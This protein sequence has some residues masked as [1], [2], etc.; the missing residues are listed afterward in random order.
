M[1]LQCCLFASHGTHLSRVY[2]LK[3][4]FEFP[5]FC[6]ESLEK[7]TNCVTEKC[8]DF[9]EESGTPTDDDDGSFGDFSCESFVKLL[10]AQVCEDN[11]CPAC[12]AEQIEH[13]ECTGVHTLELISGL[14]SAFDEVA[15]G[16][17][18]PEVEEK[19]EVKITECSAGVLSTLSFAF[20]AAIG[21]AL[22]L[23]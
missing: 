21:T 20:A 19:C 11:K 8:P 18:T 1:L 15:E 2:F 16:A 9:I 13:A 5:D 23:N 10:N 17:S 6:V 7:L 14:A 3:E 4:E 22:A 12:L